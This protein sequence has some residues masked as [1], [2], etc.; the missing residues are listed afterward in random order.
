[1]SFKKHEEISIVQMAYQ[2]Y[3]RACMQTAVYVLI[4]KVI[5]LLKIIIINHPGEGAWSRYARAKVEVQNMEVVE[6]D[7]D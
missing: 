4:L 6:K 1:M 5:L 2:L 7:H 3:S